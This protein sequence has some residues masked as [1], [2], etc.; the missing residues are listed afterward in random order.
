MDEHLD[1]LATLMLISQLKCVLKYGNSFYPNIARL[2]KPTHIQ[3]ILEILLKP[4]FNHSMLA[5]SN[6]FI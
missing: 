4:N 1:K 6:V 2:I 5:A 3:I